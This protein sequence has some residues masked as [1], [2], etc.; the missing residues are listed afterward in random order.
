M[1]LK[2][3]FLHIFL[4]FKI[5]LA[6]IFYNSN[7]VFISMSCDESIKQE[8][9]MV[10]VY[11][12][13]GK[14]KTTA[15]FGLCFRAVGRGLK[16]AMVQFMKS[17]EGYGEQTSAKDLK[18]FELFPLGLDCL[19]GRDP[20]PEDYAAAEETL[21]KAKELI[22]SDEYDLVV[23]DEV[24]VAIEWKLIKEKDVLDM[25]KGRP[26]NIEV[27]LTGR[28]ATEGIIEYADLVTEMK[29][30]KHPYDCGIMARKG[31]EN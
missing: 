25:L 9:G 22:Y 14:G 16:V 27:V 6:T 23:L 13:N 26:E 10:Q 11:T 30:I 1:I 31:I 15:A 3:N 4:I 28:Y 7:C 8:L 29:C 12:G 20:T 18:N 2:I 17:D 5:Y 21:T 24:N 19:V